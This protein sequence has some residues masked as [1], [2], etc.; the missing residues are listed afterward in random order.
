MNTDNMSLSGETID[1]GPAAY[2]D[3]YN[4]KKVFSSIDKMG[5]YSFE[6]QSKIT[7]WNLARFAETFL[8]LIDSNEK[9]AIKKIEDILNKYKKLFDQSWLIMM[10]M[11]LNLDTNNNNEE[12]VKEFL[13]LMHIYKLDYTNTFLDLENNTLDKKIFKN[14]KEKY[15]NNKLR[16]FKNVNPQIIPRNH[17]IEE[18]INEV[19]S[20]N[21]SQL[22]EFEKLLKNPYEK[23]EN[24]KYIAPPLESE[25]VF[26]TFCGT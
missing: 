18:I 1:Y 7:L 15:K 26:E 3:E 9:T 24:K 17:I 21:Y 12:I 11:K 19:Y 22:Y 25:K 13:D 2:L 6:N 20:N 5:R 14:W 23:I 10:S 4:P 8:H 16:K